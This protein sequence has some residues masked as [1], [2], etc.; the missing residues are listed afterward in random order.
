MAIFESEEE[1]EA[2]LLQQQAELEEQ[3][4]T[5]ARPASKKS[6]TENC[7]SAL[8]LVILL[9]MLGVVVALFCFSKP[10][11]KKHA[12]NTWDTILSTVAWCTGTEYNENADNLTD[13]LTFR[14]KK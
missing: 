3:G 14:K 12:D 8:N 9:A 6:A 11:D 4:V 10:G 7:L 13:R 2:Y 1:F 5:P